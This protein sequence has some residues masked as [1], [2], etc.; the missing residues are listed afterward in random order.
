MEA[1]SS[2]AWVHSVPGPQSVLARKGGSCCLPSWERLGDVP[3]QT[4]ISPGVKRSHWERT[5]IYSFPHGNDPEIPAC[6]STFSQALLEWEPG[7]SLIQPE[8]DSHL[9]STTL[10]LVTPLVTLPGKYQHLKLSYYWTFLPACCVLPLQ[11]KH[12][13]IRL[14]CS[15]PS[16]HTWRGVLYWV[17]LPGQYPG[18]LMNEQG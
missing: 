2:F 5:H 13:K 16:S 7:V 6:L 12:L 9:H 14:F 3:V 8:Q 10:P 11:W 17:G 4:A 18:Q 1:T 15:S